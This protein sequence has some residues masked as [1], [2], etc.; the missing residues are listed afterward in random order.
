MTTDIVQLKEKGKPVYLK[1]HTAAI[2]GLESYPTKVDTDKM[3]QKITKKEP[4]WT[5]AWYGG[6]AGNGNVPSKPLSKC[7][8]GW[9][10]QWQEYKEDGTLNGACYHFFLVPKQHVQ[11]PGSGGVVFLLHG[12]NA[13]SLVRKYLYVK[14]TKITGNDINASSSDT[15]SSGSKMFALSAIYEY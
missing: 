7:E 5:G 11:N 14:D 3:Y 12:Y 1:T 4:L 6:A 15:A 8:N 9:I 13:N 10:F 2:D